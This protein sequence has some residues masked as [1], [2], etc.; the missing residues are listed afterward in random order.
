M[1]LVG[2][3]VLVVGMAK[4]GVA[5]AELLLAQGAAVVATDTKKFEELPAETRLRLAS[6]DYRV[7]SPEVFGLPFDRIVLS[8]GVPPSVIPP[9]VTVPV[10]GE[11][12]FASHYL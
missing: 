6:V 11:V 12:E 1:N 7:Q 8:P 9:S 10:E 5:A 3:R 2:Q 4:S